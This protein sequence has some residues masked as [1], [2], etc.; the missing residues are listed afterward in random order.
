MTAFELRLVEHIHGHLGWLSALSLLHPAVLLR[1]RPRRAL[2]AAALSTGLVT[3]TGVL[4]VGLY[5]AY[6]ITVKPGLLLAAPRVAEAFER[7]EHLGMA[8][9][10]LSWLGLVAHLAQCRELRL[11]FPLSRLAFVAYAGA[12][13]LAVLSASLGLAVAVHSSF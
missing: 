7:K 9:V 2:L 4:G 12:A 8:V 6:R 5:P 11:A 13:A 10:A 3:L 1:A